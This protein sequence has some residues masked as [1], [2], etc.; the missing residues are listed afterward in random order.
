MPQPCVAVLGGTGQQGRGLAQRLALAGFRVI[1]GSR[2]L[3]RAAAAAGEWHAAARPAATTDYPSAIAEA[4]IVVLAVPFASVGALLDQHHGHFKSR[5][6]IVDVTVPV[7]IASGTISLGNG[8]E[9]SAAE[10][11]KARTPALTRVVATFKTVPAHLL[12][13][14][15]TQLDCDEFACGDSPEAGADAAVLVQRID[16]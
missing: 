4:E 5:T 14:I 1:V 8:A 6:L 13:E 15:Q 10:H 2:D 3:A 7:T 12:G 11:V 9:G 16:R